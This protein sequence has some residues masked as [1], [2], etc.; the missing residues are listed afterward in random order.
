MG[1]KPAI[2][3][4]MDYDSD[5]YSGTRLHEDKDEDDRVEE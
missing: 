2:M 3:F 1:L 4:D 5:G